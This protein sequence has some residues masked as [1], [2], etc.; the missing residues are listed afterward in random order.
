MTEKQ[1]GCFL[2][3]GVVKALETFAS[4]LG[5]DQSRYLEKLGV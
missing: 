1:S 3:H 2:E 5:D 4:D